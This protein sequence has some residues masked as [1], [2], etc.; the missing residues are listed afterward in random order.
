MSPRF[1]SADWYDTPHYYDIVFGTDTVCECDFLEH[2]R[3]ELS[4]IAIQRVGNHSPQ[5]E[6]GLLNSS[7]QLAKL[8][9]KIE[10]LLDEQVLDC[11]LKRA[12]ALGEK[13]IEIIR[14]K[15]VAQ[16]YVE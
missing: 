16:H 10:T 3:R 9:R 13:G 12:L 7:V 5:A 2:M 4:R 15:W 8:R 14:G 1:R 11:V 6:L